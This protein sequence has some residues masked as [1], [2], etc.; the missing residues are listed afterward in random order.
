MIATK[1]YLDSR[2]TK[3][4]RPAPLMITISIKRETAYLNTGIRILPDN[5]DAQALQARSRTVQRQADD[6]MYSVNTM[7]SKLT[8]DGTLDG[9]SAKEIRNEVRR[10]LSPKEIRPVKF[11]DVFEQYAESREKPR[12]KEIYFAT[13]K[14]IL[15]FEPGAYSLTFE[16]IDIGW[17]DR[18]DS[19]LMPTSPKKN[20]RNVHFRNIRAVFNDALKKG[21][22][23][24]Y[25]FR[26]FRV[27]PE[28][29]MK[30]CLNVEHLRT[31]FNAEV[32]PWQQ[33]YVDFFKICFMLIG[34][35]TEDIL[36]AKNTV[37][38]RL[39][40]W[41]A[42]TD[43]PYSI[44]VEPECQEL[45]DK[46]KGE[47]YLLNILDT[48]AS[49]HNWTSKVDT[50]LKTICNELGLPPISVY[51]C[52]HSWG[53]IAAELDIPDRTIAESMGHSPKTVTNIYINF[54]RTKIDRAN[55]KVLD[56]VLYDKKE[57]DM[58]EMILQL[59]EKVSKRG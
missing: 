41:R 36:H 8:E 15:D 14:K 35:N 31:L 57:Q 9:L 55:R 34:I 16:K 4:G 6:V 19:F 22:T 27:R 40:Y 26:M 33:K 28:P 7:L 44:K 2:K 29:T 1:F 3:D 47:K 46:Y 11:L 32:K 53:T 23:M 10:K 12:T 39:E 13:M 24:S 17:L 48:Y 50:E 18:F 43:K 54:D 30:R 20:A 37:G 59:N 25:P 5:W 45:L 42:K 51:W 49:T 21:I 52:R 56:F 58:F 38:G